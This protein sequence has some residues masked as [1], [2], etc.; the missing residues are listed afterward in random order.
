MPYVAVLIELPA[1]YFQDVF[2]HVIHLLVVDVCAFL[3]RFRQICNPVVSI[4]ASGKVFFDVL[5][6]IFYFYT[7]HIIIASCC[8]YDF[9]QELAYRNDSVFGDVDVYLLD[10]VEALDEIDG[11][12]VLQH[13]V[14]ILRGGIVIDIPT[15]YHRIVFV[16]GDGAC[17]RIVDV[18]NLVDFVLCGK[19]IELGGAGSDRFEQILVGVL[20]H[21]ERIWSELARRVG[22]CTVD[23]DGVF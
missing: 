16:D 15:P 9:I 3:I 17:E 7:F 6:G 18:Q 4:N 20:V 1:V 10:R 14:P 8:K 11:V 22:L 12:V 5:L 13:I 23:C 2:E 19:N 21:H